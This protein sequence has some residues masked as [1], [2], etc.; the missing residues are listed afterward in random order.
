MRK[1]KNNAGF[2]LIEL[3]CAL[4]ILVLLVM[5]IGTG[6]DAGMKIYADATFEAESASL[7]GILNTSL[8]DILRYSQNIRIN[9]DKLE[10]S[11]G[12]FIVKE[13]VGFVFTNIEYGIQDAYFY[14]PVM[15][16]NV[17]MGVL[18]MKNLRNSNVVELVNTGAYP[19]L[20]IS[21]FKIVFHDQSEAGVGGGYFTVTYNIFSESDTAKKR[22]VEM[23]VRLMND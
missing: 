20:V 12:A 1:L 5:G 8:G 19:D 22:D 16:G 18:Q 4:L 15:E 10:D 7:A 23:I 17:S 13:D 2:S 9:N 14:T 6:M 11:S 21:N 3:L